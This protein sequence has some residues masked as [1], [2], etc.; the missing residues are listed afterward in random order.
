MSPFLN[1]CFF[2]LTITLTFFAI[3]YC[4]GTFNLF[5]WDNIFYSKGIVVADCV[6]KF[7]NIVTGTDKHVPLIS[8]DGADEHVP[9]SVQLVLTNMSP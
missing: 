7:M 6:S 1:N 2:L 3:V 5:L 9:Q 4:E 8:T